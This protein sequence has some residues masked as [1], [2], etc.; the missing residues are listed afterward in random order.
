VWGGW[1]G[2]VQD[3][4]RE[5]ADTSQLC[6]LVERVINGDKED[7]SKKEMIGLADRS[8]PGSWKG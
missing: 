5:T 6:S 7:V 3:H 1:K 4:P 2:E 8:L